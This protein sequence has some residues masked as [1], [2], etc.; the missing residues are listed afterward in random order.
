MRTFDPLGEVRGAYLVGWSHRPI[1]T[2]K[3]EHWGQLGG[4]ARAGL[5]LTV[6]RSIKAPIVTA[7][8]TRTI[9]ATT[10]MRRSKVASASSKVAVHRN[11]SP[12]DSVAR[13]L[14]G[15]K[16]NGTSFES[17][18]SS[19]ASRTILRTISNTLVVTIRQSPVRLIN[20]GSMILLRTAYRTRAAEEGRFSLRITAARC[21]STVFRLMPS[22]LA[23]DLLLW[24]SA[25]N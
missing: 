19:V 4:A 17:S 2:S 10:C 12:R 8:A 6:E 21:V 20:H 16:R 3:A 11:P 1:P 25:I 9:I 22:L 13:T 7:A 5:K 23:I 14:S 18:A 24:P 15:D